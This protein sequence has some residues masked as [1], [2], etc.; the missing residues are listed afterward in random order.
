MKVRPTALAAC[1]DGVNEAPRRLDYAL[2]N[3]RSMLADTYAL[4]RTAHHPMPDILT[5]L[6][7]RAEDRPARLGEVNPYLVGVRAF[8]RFG[9]VRVTGLAAEMTYYAL[10]SLVPFVIALGAGVGF[11]EIILAADQVAQVENA[12]IRALE[13]VFNP[14]ITQE[15]LEPLVRGLLAEARTGAAILSLLATFLFSS[16]VFRAVIRVLDDA[17]RV[18]ERRGVVHVWGLAYVLSLASVVVLV[19]GLS[20]MVI[21]PLLGGGY[22]IAGLLGLGD[23]FAMVWA[24]GRWP[25]MIALATLY[26]A[27]VYTAGPNVRTRFRDAL[28]GALLAALGAILISVGLRVYLEV[29]GPRAP[30]VGDAAEAVQAASQTVAAILAVVLWIWLTSVVVLT[31]GVLNAEISRAR[32]DR[33]ERVA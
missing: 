1:Q 28:P 9:E 5:R 16:A 7:R 18:P 10:V 19:L 27:W 33:L 30:A 25:V 15:V 22:W 6:E 31:G 26:L 21:G 12:I 14:E 4:V 3:L 32:G 13:S 17:Y 11:L 8:R 24:I 23:V 29:A 2:R 20:L